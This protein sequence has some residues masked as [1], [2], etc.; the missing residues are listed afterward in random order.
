[1]KYYH[2]TVGRLCSEKAGVRAAAARARALHDTRAVDPLIAA[3]SDQ[4]ATVRVAAARDLGSL[5]ESSGLTH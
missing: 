1:M 4:A 5:G 2:P 3:L